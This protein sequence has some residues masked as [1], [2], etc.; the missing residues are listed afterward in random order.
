M[1]SFLTLAGIMLVILFS[2]FQEQDMNPL[3]QIMSSN[4]PK[5]KAIADHLDDHEVQILYTHIERDDNGLPVFQEFEFQLND[6]QYFYPASTAK[7]PVAILAI[8][9]VRELQKKGI[10]IS[11]DD[12]FVVSDPDSDDIIIETDSTSASGYPS[13]KHMI[14]KIFLVSDNDAYNYLFDFLGRDYV[15]GQLSKLGMEPSHLNHKFLYGA[16]NVHTWSFKFYNQEGELT[17]EQESITSY[18]EGH[19]LPLNGLIKGVGYTD[20]NGTLFNEPFDFS[21]KNYFSIRS[22]NRILKGVIFPESLPE[23]SKFNLTLEDMEFIKYWMS[24]NTFESNYPDYKNSGLWESYVKFFMFGD[25]KNPMPKNIRIFNKVG[26][27]Y[28]TLTDVAYI[29]DSENNIEF[30]LTATVHVNANGIFNDGV[31]EYDQLGFPFMAEL[32]RQVYQYELSKND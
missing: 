4:S 24:R 27:A 26:D 16:D 3:H 10:K 13:I 29:M 8:Q 6:D 7:L 11:L 32:G 23:G 22:L 5:I 28:G 1:R 18:V 9:K 20:N 25:N 21:E 12:R 14:K 2:S 30:M 15:N 17:Y 31:Y 19:G